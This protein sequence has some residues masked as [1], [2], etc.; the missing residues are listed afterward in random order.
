MPGCNPWYCDLRTGGITNPTKGAPLK[1][2]GIVCICWILSHISSGAGFPMPATARTFTSLATCS[3][4]RIFL[5]I[6]IGYSRENCRVACSADIRANIGGFTSGY[7]CNVSVFLI[8]SF[9][10]LVLGPLQHVSQTLFVPRRHIST[11]TAYLD[12]SEPIFRIGID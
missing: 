1:H 9:V 11:F 5:L 12:L 3:N 6:V 2:F 7:C 4:F 8:S 10:I